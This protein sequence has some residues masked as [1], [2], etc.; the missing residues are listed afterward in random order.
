M[1][2]TF[3]VFLAVAGI[4]TA[5]FADGAALYKKCAGCHGANGEKAAMNASKIIADMSKADIVAA[6]KGYKDG[7]YGGAKKAMMIGQ[8]KNLDDAS[9]Q[10]I[11]DH[12]GK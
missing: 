7:S 4:S 2:K 10:A 1:K 9:I 5:V 12:I 3:V 6:M 8:V 11:A